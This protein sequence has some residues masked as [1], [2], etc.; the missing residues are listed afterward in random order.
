[1]GENM[2]KSLLNYQFYKSFR[3]PIHKNDKVFLKVTRQKDSVTKEDITGDIVN[4]NLT[5]LNFSTTKILKDG[6][7]LRIL[8]YT[9]RF[10][11]NWDIEVSGRIVR[12][13]YEDPNSQKIVYGVLLDAVEED[14]EL[15]YFLKDFINRF[16]SSRL[17]EYLLESAVSEKKISA[18]EGIELYSLM[19]SLYITSSKD[20]VMES[21][22][23]AT[24]ILE[25][26][27]A[28]IYKIN[29]DSH[30]LEN[31]YSSNNE[32]LKDSD[33]RHGLIGNVFTS[34]SVINLDLRRLEK[35]PYN[36]HEM[37][38]TLAHPLYNRQHKTIGVI[39][40][41][42]KNGGK[43]FT[44]KDE[45]FIKLVASLIS[46]HF[47][48]FVPNSRITQ[49]EELN[50][51]EKKIE[52]LYMGTS[53]E[54]IEIRKIIN[55]LKTKTDNILIVGEDGVGKID[56]ARGIHS[57]GSTALQE[58]FHL[59]CYNTIETAM[60]I[61]TNLEKAHLDIPGALLLE[62]PGKLTIKQQ[63]AIFEI[64]SRSKKRILTVSSKDLQ[65]L[66]ESGHFL[67]KLYF[68]ISKAH[69]HLRP[70][71]NRKEEILDIVHVLIKKEADRREISVPKLD[72][73][74]ID[75]LVNHSWPENMKELQKTIKK[76]MMKYD[77]A[78]D[79]YIDVMPI[80]THHRPGKNTKMY[81]IINSLALH[82]DRSIYF[83]NH[84]K[85]LND[86]IKRKLGD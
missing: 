22:I 49:I 60:H 67:K 47:D 69:L 75:R 77:P 51:I 30:S 23:T 76:A 59:N 86:I 58:I 85:I 79:I 26:E 61:E 48:D 33:Y 50:P 45:R 74:T 2:D 40:F 6:E 21:L 27:L 54:S 13:F 5:G 56:L 4:I 17:K 8:I 32:L 55:S 62:E 38:T 64:I 81:D 28:R 66:V 53:L 44:I 72:D 46:H 9:K 35:H 12:S 24:E 3:M 78:S 29:L 83:D 25:C 31:I 82:S 20:P 84:K 7:R 18:K 39:E 71:R 10:F 37:K 14:S 63:K 68:F 15:A 16:S 57:Q 11:N 70:L 43:K 42:N 52:T 34:S 41:L 19:S 1:M 36:S 73:E 65:S 80:G